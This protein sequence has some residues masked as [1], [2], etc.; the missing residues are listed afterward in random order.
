[1]EFGFNNDSVV[2][3]KLQSALAVPMKGP[4]GMLGVLTLYQKDRPLL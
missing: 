3:Y 4:K 1:M 2:V